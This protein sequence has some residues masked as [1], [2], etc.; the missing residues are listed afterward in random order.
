MPFFFI[1]L[2]KCGIEC[3]REHAVGHAPVE[4]GVQKGVARE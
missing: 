3:R 1:L 4:D 2:T